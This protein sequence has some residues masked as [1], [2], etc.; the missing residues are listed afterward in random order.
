MRRSHIARRQRGRPVVSSL[1]CPLLVL[2]YSHVALVA[3]STT[4][5]SGIIPPP[6]PPPPPPSLSGGK[7]SHSILPGERPDG[8][9]LEKGG[10]DVNALPRKLQNGEQKI[11]LDDSDQQQGMVL[12][13][14]ERKD[15]PLLEEDN[16]KTKWGDRPGANH[17]PRKGWDSHDHP[18]LTD[19]NKQTQQPEQ[20]QSHPAEETWGYEQPSSQY[21]PDQYNQRQGQWPQT[22]NRYTSSSSQA[23][24]PQYQGYHQ[25]LPQQQRQRYEQARPTAQS[26]QL[27]RYNRPQSSTPI[28]KT[29]ASRLFSMAVRKIQTG[30]DTVTESLD[31]DKVVSSV[32]SIT[33]RLGHIGD[34]VSSGM[35]LA[36]SRTGHSGAPPRP[37]GT[38]AGTGQRYVPRPS[39]SHDP[40]RGVK[41]KEQYAPPMSELYSFDKET[42]VPE[43]QDGSG[44]PSDVPGGVAQWKGSDKK[45]ADEED[46]E[47]G[48]SLGHHTD[49]DIDDD[50]EMNT[51]TSRGPDIF[52][53]QTPS[54]PTSPKMGE[55]SIRKS[56]DL[57]RPQPISQFP[58]PRK[59]DKNRL[60]QTWPNGGSMTSSS[61]TRQQQYRDYDDDY[62]SSS[63]GSKV[64]SVIGSVPVPNIP[65]LFK[66]LRSSTDLYD[67]GAWSDDESRSK[68]KAGGVGGLFSGRKAPSTNAYSVPS[69]GSSLQGRSA[70]SRPLGTANVPRP[71][72]SLLEKR[73]NLL[74]AAGARRCASIGRTQASLDAAQLAL[75]AF[76]MR[77]AIPV[78]HK[79][80]STSGGVDNLTAMLS[81]ILTGVD[82]WVPYA[83]CAAVLISVS[84]A[85]WI[86]PSLKALS[87]EV[88]SESESE[89]SY[90]QLYLRLISSIPM[91]TSFPATVVRK[92]ARADALNA[93]STARLHFFI[94]LAVSFVLLST[95]A[96]LQP[97]GAAITSAIVQSIKLNAL[98]ER[99]IVW[100]AVL[101]EIKSIGLDLGHGLRTLFYTELNEVKQQPLR[102]VVV[103]SLLA[104]L[105]FVSYL[106]SLERSRKS[107]PVGFD[108]EEDEEEDS[109]T[110]LWSNIGSCSA[111]RLGL[112]SSLRGV[113]GALEQY[114]KLRPDRAAAAGMTLSRGQTNL[115]R[116]KRKQQRSPF[117]LRS[118]TPLLREL[119]Y[120]LSSLV[121]LVV[122]LVVYT[123]V[124]SKT[125]TDDEDVILSLKSIPM[126]GWASLLDMAALLLMTN[127]QVGRAAHYAI[128]AANARLGTSLTT[129]FQTLSNTVSELQKLAA[130]SSN[131]DFQAMLTASPTEGIVVT[132]FWAAHST[133][134]A[135]AVRGANVQCKNGEV[136]VV[137][138]SDG[139]GKSRLLTSISEHIF[140]PPKSARTT[141]FVRGSVN[142]AGVNL[143]KWDR[144]QLQRRVGVLLND[145]RTVSDY[146]SLV[147]GCTLEEILEP[148]PLV[149]GS[150]GRQIGAKEKHAMA[151]AIKITG[152]GS[153]LS[154]RLPSKLATV[155]SA[156]E[157]ELK[158][159]PLRPPSYP[160]SPSDWSRV[161]LTKVL[162]QLIAGNDNQQASPNSIT[163]CLIGSILLLDDA[164][165][166]MSEV[167]EAT[168]ITALRN[169]GAAVILTS[170]RW[171]TGRFADRIIVI[172]NGVIVESGTH[173]DLINLGP[174]RSLYAMQWNA[175]SSV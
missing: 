133:R 69:S 36:G 4:G 118:V 71:V 142:V 25:Q 164:T 40:R 102:V 30:L 171:T 110:S 134:Q 97:A 172:E 65:K 128:G 125:Q 138:G 41:P 72:M 87:S 43:S 66:G 93:A 75:V 74:S 34:A 167:D 159:S 150:P 68:S 100:S 27:M 91:K 14:Y 7:F 60:D 20:T 92:A 174:E 17:S 28:S 70:S 146:A 44:M 144:G 111:T 116:R 19:T 106:P 18:K 67:D 101:E 85:A 170:N 26:Q 114:S 13:V 103:V 24:Y 169:T 35:G 155:V 137:I 22:P 117:L 149:G 23:Y 64:K 16:L 6:P 2:S 139:A 48:E 95:V 152:L 11:S 3:A 38:G 127:I 126:E 135:W 104:S 79:A 119:A 99:P 132:D 37:A 162:A 15:A 57:R 39:I 89:A 50:D 156:N 175:M 168:C 47:F 5:G 158:P 81:T 76:A 124:W 90:T 151:L 10:T 49:S 163:K 52:K 105:L 145:V 140:A 1:L 82:G 153:K 63:I 121:V 8:T 54:A 141:T 9:V 51:A 160:L 165:S 58:P 143:S 29:S 33:S 147:T 55:G 107:N 83:L 131:S 161:L 84:H 12:P 94:T 78:F 53:M 113:E 122:P 130:A 86:V 80:V 129:F 112:L 77:E 46:E 62:E 108:E 154:S 56:S 32:S 98:K 123:Y 136:V 88:A 96:V 120:S 157:D 45:S 173:S 166:Q 42:D 73:G 21:Y 31:T 61:A 115:S 109:I 148:I 59:T